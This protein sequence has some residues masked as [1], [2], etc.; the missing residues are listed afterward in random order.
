MKRQ[1][2]YRLLALL[3][4][5][6]LSV[7]TYGQTGLERLAVHDVFSGRLANTRILSETHVTGDEL[8][9]YHLSVFRSVQCSTSAKGFAQAERL[10]TQDE[11]K[12][13]E[14]EVQRTNRRTQYALFR[15]AQKD[16]TNHYIIYQRRSQTD[17]VCVYLEGTAS[18]Q[19]LK[20]TFNK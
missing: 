16:G 11:Q 18:I 1:K 15:Y 9:K 6:C 7:T 12:A 19:Q 20:K 17:F 10:L 4:V 2:P 13:T 5:L 14:K 3:L 8:A